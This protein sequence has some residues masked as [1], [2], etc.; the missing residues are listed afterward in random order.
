MR[1]V[2]ARPSTAARIEA[3]VA[4]N[5]S[6]PHYPVHDPEEAAPEQSAKDAAAN[7][8][9][10]VARVGRNGAAA[11]PTGPSSDSP[12][13]TDETKSGTMGSTTNSAGP[14]P[15]PPPPK[16]E[17]YDRWFPPE[18]DAGMKLGAGKY[19]GVGVQSPSSDAS[20]AELHSLALTP[21]YRVPSPVTSTPAPAPPPHRPPRGYDPMLFVDEDSAA[22][23]TASSVFATPREL[24]GGGSVASFASFADNVSLVSHGSMMSQHPHGYDYYNSSNAGGHDGSPMPSLTH[25]QSIGSS[26]LTSGVA[27]APPPARPTKTTMTVTNVRTNRQMPAGSSVGPTSPFSRRGSRADS[28]LFQSCRSLGSQVSSSLTYPAPTPGGDLDDGGGFYSCRSL[29]TASQQSGVSSLMAPSGASTTVSTFASPIHIR[30]PPSSSSLYAMSHHSSNS[31]SNL[32]D[33]SSL[34]PHS[35]RGSPMG[36][37]G[38]TPSAQ[39]EFLHYQ[40]SRQSESGDVPASESFSVGGAT[41]GDVFLDL[42]S[43]AERTSVYTYDDDRDLQLT[44][45]ERGHGSAVNS[46]AK[47]QAPASP[48]SHYSSSSSSVTAASSSPQNTRTTAAPDCGGGVPASMGSLSTSSISSAWLAPPAVLT[49]TKLPTDRQ[50]QPTASR[51]GGSNSSS[52]TARRNEKAAKKNSLGSSSSKKKAVP[53]KQ[54]YTKADF[55]PNPRSSLP[56]AR[57]VTAPPPAAAAAAPKSPCAPRK[58]ENISVP[59]PVET[60]VMME[61]T[62]VSLSSPSE[63]S[64]RKSG[65]TRP[66]LKYPGGGDREIDGDEQGDALRSR[67]LLNTQA[68]SPEEKAPSLSPPQQPQQQHLLPTSSTPPTESSNHSFSTVASSYRRG[69]QEWEQKGVAEGGTLVP[70]P[71]RRR[72]SKPKGP[73]KG[74]VKLRSSLPG[75]KVLADTANLAPLTTNPNPWVPG[76]R[77]SSTDSAHAD[78]FVLDADN[79]PHP[80]AHSTTAPSASATTPRTGGSNRGPAAR[81]SAAPPNAGVVAGRPPAAASAAPATTQRRTQREMP[82]RPRATTE[83]TSGPSLQMTPSPT[84]KSAVKPTAKLAAAAKARRMKK[85]A[86]AAATASKSSSHPTTNTTGAADLPSPPAPP[87]LTTPA[88]AHAS[89]TGDSVVEYELFTGELA[90]S[91]ADSRDSAAAPRG[92]QT[93]Q[94]QQQPFLPSSHDLSTLRNSPK[95]RAGHR[96][97]AG[98]HAS[99]DSASSV[100]T[101]A[102]ASGFMQPYTDAQLTAHMNSGDADLTNGA[103]TAAAAATATTTA[104]TTATTAAATDDGSAVMRAEMANAR[105]VQEETNDEGYDADSGLAAMHDAAMPPPPPRS[106]SATSNDDPT[107]LGGTDRATAA[108]AKETA[109]RANGVMSPSSAASTGKERDSASVNAVVLSSSS[110]A[111]ETA[112]P[113]GSP[114]VVG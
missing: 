58:T 30:K 19:N 64:T 11:N 110:S 49:E 76:G 63:T 8:T 18:H 25:R 31:L 51:A 62:Y 86:E 80:R 61:S 72:S 79:H 92:A 43:A 29:G 33:V 12:H 23:E 54:Y 15:P 56:Q 9:S 107:V 91:E 84:T 14:P 46:A 17:S 78:P 103:W 105:S 67:A 26:S 59:L 81:R 112:S 97:R 75:K 53:S 34:P 82:H 21:S 73:P 50:R 96:Q 1:A 52:G 42:S 3:K 24:R 65:A 106:V 40:A 13:K 48:T 55:P 5:S 108:A 35:P 85:A 104:S 32:R 27:A 22:P 36:Y 77:R 47:G 7:F 45:N 90:D 100:L 114:V 38:N 71:T 39:Q 88:A 70:A 41:P 60:V 69:E 16:G 37:H 44:L 20:S 113:T 28:D 98:F 93:Q 101:S 74:S 95:T 2:P 57:T 87:A 109:P 102:E 66:T 89:D 68:P 99:P 4:S 111:S 94:Q 10:F 6:D 83:A